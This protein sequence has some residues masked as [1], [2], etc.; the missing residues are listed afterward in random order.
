MDG[1]AE[2][3]PT[4]VKDQ[5]QLSWQAEPDAL[6]TVVMTGELVDTALLTLK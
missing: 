3:T 1:G 4:Q 2:L 6:Y 5:P